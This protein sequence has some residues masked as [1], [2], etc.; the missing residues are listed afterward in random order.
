LGDSPCPPD[1]EGGLGQSPDRRWSWG[2]GGTA[3]GGS[4]ARRGGGGRW[5]GRVGGE[6]V[7]VTSRRSRISGGGRWWRIRWRKPSETEE[8][9]GAG[10]QVVGALGRAGKGAVGVCG[11]TAGSEVAAGCGWW[12]RPAMARRAPGGGGEKKTEE[13]DD[14]RLHPRA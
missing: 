3:G 12:W 2:A 5:L 14:H 11:R 6:G 4:A 9:G 8:V 1:L 10:A 7:T 13:E